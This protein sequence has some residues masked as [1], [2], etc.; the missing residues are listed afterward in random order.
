MSLHSAMALAGWIACVNILLRSAMAI[1]ARA[2]WRT[3]YWRPE[4]EKLLLGKLFLRWRGPCNCSPTAI[5]GCCITTRHSC[6]WLSYHL[7]VGHQ[8]SLAQLPLDN[9]SPYISNLR[10]FFNVCMRKLLYPLEVTIHEFPNLL[11][12]GASSASLS[13]QCLGEPSQPPNNPTIHEMTLTTL[14]AVHMWP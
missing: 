14:S 3:D 9:V 5:T 10:Q 1:Q 11:A 4:D 8:P 6:D 7:G 2:F 13:R 12:Y